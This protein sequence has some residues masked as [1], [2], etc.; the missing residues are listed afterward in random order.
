[1]VVMD[2]LSPL[3]PASF[4]NR[5]GNSFRQLD[6]GLSLKVFGLAGCGKTS[7]FHH[8]YQHKTLQQ[9]LGLSPNT[10]IY[11]FDLSPSIHSCKQIEIYLSSFGFDQNKLI[12]IIDSASSLFKQPR[13]QS[14][15]F[16]YYQS[17]RPNLS[18]VYLFSKTYGLSFLSSKI[19]S[20]KN[21]LVESTYYY[22]VFTPTEINYS[23]ANWQQRFSFKIPS[24]ISLRISTLSGGYPSLIKTLFFIYQ[25][26]PSQFN[27]IDINQ[28]DIN[29]VLSRLY[30]SLTK[31]QKMLLSRFVKQEPVDSHSIAYQQLL[32]LGL[33]NPSGQLFS[34]LFTLFIKNLTYTT[35]FGLRFLKELTLS[36][37]NFLNLLN[38]YKGQLINRDQVAQVLWGNL[39]QEKY[40]DW[41]IDKLLS[42]LR[43]KIFAP[44]RS[45]LEVVKG[46]GFRLID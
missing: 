8:I 3:P 37:H 21:S 17:N 25:N 9:T 2:L 44:D 19:P 32:D 11:Y 6:L 40:S 43:Q 7:T 23:L 31:N 30:S 26:S 42:Q 33:I 20:L 4:K 36:E 12:L 28:P 5:L 14:L 34:A 46:R 15:L 29:L 10:F 1:M 39:W 45:V 22:S 27:Q 41:A 16:S 35:Y 18:F 38:Q 24:D 13:L